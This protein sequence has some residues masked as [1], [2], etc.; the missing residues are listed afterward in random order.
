M[1]YPLLREKLKDPAVYSAADAHW[2]GPDVVA[3]GKS[4]KLSAISNTE[5]SVHMS[6]YT[7]YFRKRPELFEQFKLKYLFDDAWI[8]RR[9]TED[10][11]FSQ[12]I[13]FR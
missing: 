7:P 4:S 13:K 10:A 9:D 6:E 2:A 8:T 5:S 3:G 1:F 11:E 12:L